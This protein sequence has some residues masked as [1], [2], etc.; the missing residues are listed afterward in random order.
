M[1]E[2]AAFVRDLAALLAPAAT[3]VDLAG[4]TGRN[5]IWLASLGHAVTLVDISSVA[6]QAAARAARETG[7]EL[8]TVERDLEADGPPPGR[9]WD[10]VL[11]HYYFD[12]AVIRA[13]WDAVAPGGLLALAQPTVTN[14]ERH[15]RPG[16]RF[17]LEAG[18]AGRLADEF[19]TSAPVEVVTCTEGW[20]DNGRHEG[21]LVLRRASSG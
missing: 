2:P 19:A 21:R 13:A 1:G 4:G 11:M 9:T 10:L 6:L 16:R 18:Q 17:L 8:E 3:A 14:L 15:D 20:Q 12:A 5:A 7:I